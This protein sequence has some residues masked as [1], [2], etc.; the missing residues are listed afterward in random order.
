MYVL[1]DKMRLCSA[2]HGMRHAA[3]RSQISGD[4]QFII[5][6]ASQPEKITLRHPFRGDSRESDRAHA[7]VC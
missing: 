3:A 1:S 5:K 6:T 7:A 4:A 2:L